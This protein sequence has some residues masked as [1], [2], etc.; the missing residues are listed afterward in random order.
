[1]IQLIMDELG[2]DKSKD[3]ASF[4]GIKPNTLSNW[5]SRNTFDAELIYTKCDFINPSWLLTGNG[6]MI[7]SYSRNTNQL[8]MV[9]EKQASYGII[10]QQVPVYDL[11][12]SASI[13]QVF[14]NQSKIIP[15]DHIHIPNLPKCDGAISISGDSMYPLL[16]S[17]DM[18]LYKEVQN[19]QNIIW[20]EMYVMYINNDG[21]EFFFVKYIQK[22]EIEGYVKL[23]SQNVNH[24]PVDFPMDSIK[25]LAKVQASIRVNSQV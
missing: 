11:T 5:M 17:G 19:K 9:N 23:V 2:I 18:I 8:S 14:S 21:D 1:M 22:S 15:M 16:K 10:N 20:G 3:F 25:H 4:L 7:K 24:Q 6:E 12:A 13:E